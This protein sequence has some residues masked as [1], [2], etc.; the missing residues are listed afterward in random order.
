MDKFARPVAAEMALD[1]FQI[2][3]GR[4]PGLGGQRQSQEHL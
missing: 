2:A 3:S 1:A 4:I